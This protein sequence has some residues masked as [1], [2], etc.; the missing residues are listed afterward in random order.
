MERHPESAIPADQRGF[1]SE[2]WQR[3]EREADADVAAGRVARLGFPE[4][5]LAE[6]DEP[7]R[8]RP[9]V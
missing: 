7:D 6:L 3:M 2:R 8:P 1:W 9:A 5:L 4:D